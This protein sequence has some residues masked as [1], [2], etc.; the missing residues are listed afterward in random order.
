MFPIHDFLK[1][2][3]N[4]EIFRIQAVAFDMDGLIFNS[5]D[6]YFETG[7][8]LLA[9]FG[10]QYTHEL[11]DQL[12]GCTPQSAFEKMIAWHQLP[13]TWQELQKRSNQIFLSIMPEYLQPMPG[14]MELLDYLDGHEIPHAICTSSCRELVSQMLPIHGLETR[15]DFIITSEDV[16]HSK[17]EP[18]IYLKAASRFGVAP[19]NMMVLEDSR[20]DCL[21]GANAGAFV[22]AVPGEHS[23]HHDFSM[24]S[25]R[26]ERLNDAEIFRILEELRS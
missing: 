25:C 19:E 17:P 1:M 21:A 16:T 6:V 26:L 3:T 24:V 9:E 14:L 7:T 2:K 13:V 12:M 10:F 18:E 8:R 20:N 5:E 15:F 22:T 23:R 11:S 4:R